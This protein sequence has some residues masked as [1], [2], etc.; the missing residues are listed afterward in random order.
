MDRFTT[1]TDPQVRAPEPGPVGELQAHVALLPMLRVGP[2]LTHDI[3]PLGQ[4]PARQISELGLEARL[5]PPI[6]PLPWRT[7][8]FI[9]AGY[10][11]TYQPSYEFWHTTLFVPGAGG[12]FVDTRL[13]VGLGYRL[14]RPWEIFVELGGRLGFAFTG[15]MYERSACECGVYFA[16]K[17]SFALSLSLGLSLYQ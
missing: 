4:A 3:S 13:G 11:R 9:G 12:G 2:Y 17:D 6:L 1:G 7:W 14:S 5:T 15:S 8:A 16:G 10:A